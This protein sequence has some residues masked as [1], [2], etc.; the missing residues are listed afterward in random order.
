MTDGIKLSAK[1]TFVD[2][3][4]ADEITMLHPCKQRLQELLNR[5]SENPSQLGLENDG[6]NRSW[7]SGTLEA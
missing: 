7:N 3:D 1:V 5:V 6:V 2:L 4:F